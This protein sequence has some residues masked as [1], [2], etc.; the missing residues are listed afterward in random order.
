MSRA[1]HDSDLLAVDSD[2]CCLR[3]GVPAQR[4]FTTRGALGAHRYPA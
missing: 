4:A 2:L 1:L 3:A